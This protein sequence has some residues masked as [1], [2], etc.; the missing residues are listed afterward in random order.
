MAASIHELPRPGN[1]R[2]TSPVGHGANY[3]QRIGAVAG[4]SCHWRIE[5]PSGPALYDFVGGADQLGRLALASRTGIKDP[6]N[7]AWC[8]HAEEEL[9]FVNATQPWRGAAQWRSGDQ[10][11]ICIIEAARMAGWIKRAGGVAVNVELSAGG[12]VAAHGR[13]DE[14]PLVL[15]RQHARVPVVGEIARRVA[16]LEQEVPEAHG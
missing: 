6:L 15:R 3:D 11:G 14:V 7:F 9:H 5:R 12:P 2:G 4:G 8:Q 1:Y 16:Q 10:E 13:G